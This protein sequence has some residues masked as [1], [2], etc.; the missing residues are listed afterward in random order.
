[1]KR[2]EAFALVRE[3]GGSPREGVT[4]R[5]D[6]L[7]VGELGWPLVD[8]GR[9]SN[10]LSQARSYGVPVA[11]ER[12]F[13]EW[14]GRSATEEQTRTYTADQLA[15]LSKVPKDILD[16][17][18]MFGLIEPK[19]GLYGFTDLAAAR[20]IA[21]LLASGV[22]L[23]VI[24]RSLH[25]IRKWL[26]D[27]RLSNLRLFPESSDRILIE[28]MKGRTDQ[29]GQFMLPVDAG[30]DDADALFR[31]AQAAEDTDDA[32]T[33]E[34]LYRRLIKIDAADAAARFNL[35]NLLR[36][37]GRAVEAEAMYREATR[38][39]PGFGPAWY[40]L[41]DVLDEAGRTGDAIAALE[42][43]TKADPDYAD[44]IF[45]LALL[46]QKLE[47]HAEA[48]ACWRR[49]LKLDADSSW[50]ARA[51]RALKFCEIKLADA[52]RGAS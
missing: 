1:M 24:T 35:A 5:T 2:A 42:A 14:L 19:G 48:A 36:A 21:G 46:L 49:Y 32:A 50:S 18:A 6:V 27:A 33:A 39:D 43:A 37:S 17:L 4:K 9:P 29:T 28:Q 40:N 41:A 15:S 45:N 3:R 22:A 51:R 52:T 26:P 38:A 34:R 23:S 44:A 20:Q 12:Q 30:S 25:D 13:L 31:A 10:S 8:D 11:S 16:Q 7:V 47:R